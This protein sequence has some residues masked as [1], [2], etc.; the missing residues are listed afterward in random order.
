VGG[1]GGG[2]GGGG[3]G[4]VGGGGG[5]CS[6]TPEGV[7]ERP[8]NLALRRGRSHDA[9][10]AREKAHSSHGYTG[11][12]QAITPEVSRIVTGYPKKKKN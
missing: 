4:G 5:W 1:W 2:G 3:G 7:I 8:I 11:E 9:R 12:E 10:P 6:P